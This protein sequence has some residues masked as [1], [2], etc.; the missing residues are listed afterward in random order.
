MITE[1]DLLEFGFE[2]HDET[3]ESTGDDHEWHYY[4]LD[5]ED[6]CFITNSSD[7]VEDGNWKVYI[8]DYDGFEFNQVGQVA[9]IINILKENIKKVKGND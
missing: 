4:T 8:F 9:S 1:Q 7:E 6:F 5:I 2:R 3:P